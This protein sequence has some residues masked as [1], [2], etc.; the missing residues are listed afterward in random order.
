[1]EPILAETIEQPGSGGVPLDRRQRL[2]ALG[3]A[4]GLFG[5]LTV[6]YWLSPNPRGIGTHQQ[7]GLPPCTF[8]T[9]FRIPCPTCGMTTS[10]SH[11]MHGNV[12][13]SWSTNPGG[14][15]LAVVAAIAG[16]WSLVTSIRGRYRRLIP[17]RVAGAIAIG[18]TALTLIA[19]CGRIF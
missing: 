18:I 3:L 6:S 13:E 2:W 4:C 1:M 11:L 15:C 19:W 8:V 5:L 16:T 10:W 14:T 12:S 17:A 9:L 7:L